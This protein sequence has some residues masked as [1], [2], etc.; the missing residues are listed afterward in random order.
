VGATGAVGSTGATGATGSTGPA[1]P[2]FLSDQI[3][4][5][6]KN[7]NDTTGNGSVGNPFL[8]I[9]KAVSLANN[10]SIGTTVIVQPGVYSE[11][12]SLSNRNVSIMG[13]GNLPSQQLNTTISGNHTYACSTGTNSVMFSNLLMANPNLNTSLIAMSGASVGS[14][15]LTGI[16]MGDTGTNQLTN[17]V[18]VSGAAHRL[19]IERSTMVNSAQTLTSPMILCDTAIATIS[20]CNFATA[21]TVPCLRIAGASNPLNLSFSSLLCSGATSSALGVVHLATALGSTQTHAIVSCG[22]NS[23]ALASS[24]SAGGTPSVGLDATGSSLIFFNNICLTRFWVGGAFTGDTVAATGTGATASTTTYYEGSHA[25][26]NNFARGI[27]SGGNYNKAQMLA[28][29]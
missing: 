13:T 22:I 3:Y 26:V 18:N 10:N 19:T 9:A 24:S 1:G 2:P 28:I 16:L 20:L 7:G 12:L 15:T 4:W 5:V 23:S 6:A 14:L 25:T 21:S 29:N 8:T 11:N 27:V 17:Y